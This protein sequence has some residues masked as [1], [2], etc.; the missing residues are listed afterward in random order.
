MTTKDSPAATK[1]QARLEE[2]RTVCDVLLNVVAKHPD[3]VALRSY[4][5][6]AEWTYAQAYA[7]IGAIAGR[8]RSLGVGRGDAV[9]LMMRNLPEF[10]V[11]DAA[12]MV[13]GAVPFSVY[14]T[15]SPD[16]VRFLLSDAGTRLVVA[17]SS[18][19]PVLRQAQ[20]L[21]APITQIL[22]IDELVDGCEDLLRELAS[23]ETTFDFGCAADL[24]PD[25]PL[26]I[27][28]TSGTMGPPKGVEL[29]HAGMLAQLRAVHAAM[30]LAG[31]GRQVGFLPAAHVADRWSSHYSSFMTYGNTL[32]TVA[33]V[34]NLPAAVASTRPTFF[35]APPRVWE[36]FKAAIEASYSGDLLA[37]VAADPAIAAG[38]RER[39]GLAD[40]RWIIT[41]SAPT[42]I[43]VVEFFTA[44]GLPL[45]EV[46][47]MSE[48]SGCPAG[49]TPDAIR[50]GSVGRP[51]AQVETAMAPDGELLIRSPQVM[52]GYRGL[53][54]RT[55]ET[56]DPDGW[57]HTGDIV[58]IDED[59]F[60]WIIDRKKELIISAGGKNMSPANIELAV[61]S[62]GTLIGQV[63][64]IGD[65]RPYNVALIVLEPASMG[66][67]PVVDAGLAEEVRAQVERANVNLSRVEQIKKFTILAEQW[68]PGA[69]LTPTMK[70]RRQVIAERY[71]DEID[72][73]YEAE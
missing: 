69:E 4:E 73:L 47:G 12:A 25:D 65:G 64:V 70:L 6:G 35:G 53:P 26:T 9:A 39:L 58:R 24:Q 28:Y 33:D 37:D 49:N 48:T 43:A 38:V 71:A 45:C 52:R 22:V 60:L 20:S 34:S 16:Q 68:S 2:A 14:N 7:R 42:P 56:I 31:G 66:G 32:V 59:G 21:G 57:L 8:L 63:C 3:R 50:P 18:F 62:A 36:K 51:F 54:E 30:P 11:A 29:T 55:A 61:R 15:S 5:S 41:G 13:L 46:L 72:R 19:V 44:L 67:R 17:E 40:T 1:V 27:I 23:D 10:H